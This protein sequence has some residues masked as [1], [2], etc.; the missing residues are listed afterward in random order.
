MNQFSELLLILHLFAYDGLF[1][2]LVFCFS[3]RAT[4]DEFLKAFLCVVFAAMGLAQA[5]VRQ[6]GQLSH[7]GQL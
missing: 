1:L 3:P 2:L 7:P 5:Q 6:P 4:F